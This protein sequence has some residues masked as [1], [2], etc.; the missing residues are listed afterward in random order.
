MQ[1]DSQCVFC[2]SDASELPTALKICDLEYSRL[3]LFREQHYPGRCLLVSKKH[4][5]EFFDLPSAEQT[6]FLKE[7]AAV[8][9]TIQKLYK[10]DK[11][12]LL[13]LGDSVGHLHVHIVPKKLNSDEWGKMF[14][15]MGTDCF[16]SDDEYRRRID[17]IYRE[18]QNQL[19]LV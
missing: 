12:N 11:L 19:N 13:S 10:A 3:F 4:V 18:L 15:V 14:L 6:G 9:K 16:L 7:L 5:N 2:D 17:L 8:S 1:K